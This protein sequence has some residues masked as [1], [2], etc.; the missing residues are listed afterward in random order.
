MV[1]E[2]ITFQVKQTVGSRD[3]AG[4]IFIHLF[5]YLLNK[6]ILVERQILFLAWGKQQEARQTRSPM[7]SWSCTLELDGTETENK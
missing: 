1:K 7:L 2:R 5:S 3:E 6:Q 4:G